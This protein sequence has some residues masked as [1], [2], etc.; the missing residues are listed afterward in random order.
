MI[1][2]VQIKTHNLILLTLKI[3]CLTYNDLEVHVLDSV[4]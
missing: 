3:M 4:V 1:G 2:D